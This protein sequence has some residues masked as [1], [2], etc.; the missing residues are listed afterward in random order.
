MLRASEVDA[1]L[2][3]QD[4]EHAEKRLKYYHDLRAVQAIERNPSAL[5][6]ERERAAAKRQ[7]LDADR[8]ELIA[9]LLA[10]RRAL[11]EAVTKLA[12]DR[13]ARRLRAVLRRR[14]TTLD[15]INAHDHVRPDR[16]GPLPD[17]RVPHA[18]G[19]AGR[20]GLPR[21]DLPEHAPLA[22]HAR[23][24]RW[25][26]AITSIVNKNLIEMIACLALVFI[27]TGHWVGLDALLFN[28]RDRRRQRAR[29]DSRRE[30][31]RTIE[32]RPQL[33][34]TDPILLS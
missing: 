1:D 16:D 3:F 14:W 29:D 27:P 20:R 34:D 2:W 25:P 28:W 19:G 23:Q 24:P 4:S 33:K 26:R 31:P 11:R 32:P 12:T 9:D 17:G 5:S 13:A 7:D 18:P 10:R 8:R 22:R 6:Y 15:W 21:A 30:L